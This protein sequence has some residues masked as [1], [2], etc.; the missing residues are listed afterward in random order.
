MTLDP[1]QMT[2]DST[3]N[4]RKEIM[5][6]LA[7]E[8]VFEVPRRLQKAGIFGNR[9]KKWSRSRLTRRELDALTA[10]EK[11][12]VSVEKL[13]SVGKLVPADE[14][15][16]RTR[17][18]V[19]AHVMGVLDCS[20]NPARDVIDCLVD[21]DLIL[22]EKEKNESFLVFPQETQDAMV[23]LRAIQGLID[24]LL[25]AEMRGDQRTC[26]QVGS[27]LQ[28]RGVLYIATCEEIG[29]MM[30]DQIES[31]MGIL[32]EKRLRPVGQAVKAA[33]PVAAGLLVLCM[34]AIAIPELSI[35]S[36]FAGTVGKSAQNIM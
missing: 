33:V 24:T 19:D 22:F 3:Q 12:V 25:S 11:L 6:D 1:T 4:Y 9:P 10:I 14:R 13:V 5:R 18:Y 17:G 34:I 21:L 16:T 28:E 8:H 20:R 31:K 15:V 27:W 23:K 30:L 36:D 35:A 26:Q 32:E 7:S 2:L 29:I